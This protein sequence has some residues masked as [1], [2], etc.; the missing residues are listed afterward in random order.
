[1]AGPGRP[2][3]RLYFLLA[4]EAPVGVLFRRGPSRWVQLIRWN[5]ADDTFEPGQWF[6]GRI[7]EKRSDLSPDGRRLIYFAQKLSGRTL[8]EPEYTYAWTAISR[9]PYLTALALW[10]KGDC[11][12]GGGLFETNTRVWL[13]H[14]AEQ[15]QPHRRHQPRGL[16]IGYTTGPRGED[17]TARCWNRAWSG[18]AGDWS[19]HGRGASWRA[20]SPAPTG[21]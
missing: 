8:H 19:G 21:R 3:C 9:P 16:E 7:Y 20:G 18:T 13:N 5:T 10:P 12:N 2:P 1:M 11:W 4:R 14:F 17:R 6:R 15:G